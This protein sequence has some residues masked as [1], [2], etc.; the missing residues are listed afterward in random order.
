MV[1][2]GVAN[3]ANLI[4]VERDENRMTEFAVDGLRDVSLAVGI[5]DQEYFA[6][7]DDPRFTVAGRDFHRRIEIDDV[8]LPRRR[9]PVVA[10]TALGGSKDNAGSGKARRYLAAGSN[11]FGL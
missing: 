5:L 1:A 11:A 6:R 10:V 2:T 3:L 7:S 9:V 8:L 4:S